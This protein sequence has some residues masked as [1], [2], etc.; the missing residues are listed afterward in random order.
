MVDRVSARLLRSF[1]LRGSSYSLCFDD[2]F[3]RYNVRV[4][5]SFLQKQHDL[6]ESEGAAVW[7][8]DLIWEAKKKDKEDADWLKQWT[9]QDE[10]E[11]VS[12]SEDAK[13]IRDLTSD[14]HL[15][16]VQYVHSDYQTLSHPTNLTDLCHLDLGDNWR[17]NKGSWQNDKRVW[18]M[19][20]AL[21]NKDRKK[22][23]ADLGV[24]TITDF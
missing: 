5:A 18:K 17:T 16:S 20:D 21:N 24:D 6:Q 12:N 2:L 1:V 14:K 23:L 22:N 10:D 3:S 19:K 15:A 7:G 9:E 13:A 4:E 8:N 11:Q